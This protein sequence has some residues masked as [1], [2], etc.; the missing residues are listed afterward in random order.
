MNMAERC[1]ADVDCRPFLTQARRLVSSAIAADAMHDPRA[2]GPGLEQVEHA[3]GVGYRV[4]DS[5]DD[6]GPGVG[7]WGG[8]AFFTGRGGRASGLFRLPRFAFDP[9]GVGGVGGCPYMDITCVCVRAR[10]DADK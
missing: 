8:A 5:G 7:G 4:G 2:V 1:S 9:E 3:M 10:D 6:C